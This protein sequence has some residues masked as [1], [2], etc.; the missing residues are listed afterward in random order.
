MVVVVPLTIKLPVTVSSLSIVTSELN[1]VAV[2]TLIPLESVVE[3]VLPV[4]RTAPPVTVVPLTVLPV[5]SIIIVES[6]ANTLPIMSILS[7]KL[8]VTAPVAADTVRPAPAV[9]LNTPVF[10]KVILFV[11]DPLAIVLAGMVHQP[12]V[13]L[14]SRMPL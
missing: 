10:S 12:I 13:L 4:N 2:I 11:N 8:T 5:A 9:K 7:L 3:I 14:Q 1:V 6:S